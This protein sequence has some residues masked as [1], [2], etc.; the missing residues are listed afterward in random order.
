MVLR[1]LA[2][3]FR[4]QNWAVVFSELLI[5]IVGVYIGLQV[6][7]WNEE[8]RDAQRRVQ[9]IGA[10]VTSLNDAISV[11]KKMVAEIETGLSS[12]EAA[13]A[14]GEQRPPF[15]YRIGGSDIPPDTWST[16]VQMQ[17]TDLFDPVTLFDLMFFYSEFNGVGQ[18]YIR[19]VTFVEDQ[20]LPGI[21]RDDD[22]FYG[23]DGQLKPE[24]QANMDRLRDYQQETL[25]L[26]TWADCLVYRLKANRTFDQTC[27]RANF[28]LEYGLTNPPTDR[29]QHQ[30]SS[31]QLMETDTRFL[32]TYPNLEN[33]DGEVLLENEHVAV[34]KFIVGPGEWEGIHAHPGNQ[35]YVHL[36]GGEWSGRAGGEPTYTKS[37]SADGSAGWTEAIPLSA[38][39]ESGNTGDT[40]I[41]L[42]WVTLK[43]NAPIAPEV[44]HPPQIYPN[45][46]LELLLEN[47]RVIVQ[48][49][50]VEPGQ[51][52]GIHSHPGNQ[53]AIH[54]K[55]G[56]WSERIGG[57]QSPSSTVREAGAVGW[58][59]AIDLS[60]EHESG[61]TGDT[62]IDLIWVTLK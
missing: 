46:P 20:V 60:E 42:I 52:E 55:G 30:N 15:F 37:D 22:I 59:D 8:R 11:Q 58:V 4:A 27:I 51:W 48:R 32:L 6:N 23:T 49:V 7:T 38:E 33:P 56:T 16:F 14:R 29:A 17:L 53:V 24:F 34:Q 26:T 61:N 31:E 47:D 41:E 3:N 40:P 39:H 28:G 45:I 19:Y 62:T 9:I 54:L 25:R 5:V 18:K 10:L 43:G 36:Q 57:V 50:Q 44:E 12:W 21:I 1:R 35:V 13:V 2:D